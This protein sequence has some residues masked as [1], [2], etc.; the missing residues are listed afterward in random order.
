MGEREIGRRLVQVRGRMPRET[1]A[2]LLGISP[3]TLARY[4]RGERS[5]DANLVATLQREFGVDPSW[6][7]TG[8][9][10]GPGIGGPL[11][12]RRY[13]SVDGSGLRGPED[14][15]GSSDM[16]IPQ[17]ANPDPDLF[18]FVPMAEAHLSAG[19]GAFVLSEAFSD[20]YA[21]RKDWLRRIAT[22]PKNAVLVQVRGAS[23]WPTIQEGDVVMLDTGRHRIYDGCI[24][25]MGQYDTISVKRLERLAD[26][27]IRVISDNRTEFPPYE[28][29]LEDIRILGQIVWYAR[30]LVRKGD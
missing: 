1:F 20:Y 21:F 9:G 10:T 28:T 25:A 11:P 23:M 3:S 16:L 12:G 27:R 13:A 29:G 15:S 18:D 26:G 2:P 24:Y 22:S 14:G 17:W 6:F 19:G 30:E 4:E 5:P 8:S 7:V